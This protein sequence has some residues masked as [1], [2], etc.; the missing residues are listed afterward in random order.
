MGKLVKTD[1]RKPVKIYDEVPTRIENHIY[2]IIH[3]ANRA[4]KFPIQNPVLLK[5]QTQKKMTI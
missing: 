4:K 1:E 5:F 3:P 2:N